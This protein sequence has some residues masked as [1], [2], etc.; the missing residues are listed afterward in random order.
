[1][2]FE[3]VYNFFSQLRAYFLINARLKGVV[4]FP[5]IK[6]SLDVLNFYKFVFKWIGCHAYQVGGIRCQAVF[7]LI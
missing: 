1:M 5:P 2:L 4:G 6:G 3:H 7:Y